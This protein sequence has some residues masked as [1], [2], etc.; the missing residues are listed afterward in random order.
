MRG[1]WKSMFDDGT[2]GGLFGS[3]RAAEESQMQ[4][5]NNPEPS[6][7]ISAKQYDHH[8]TSGHRFENYL[9]DEPFE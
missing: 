9:V 6:K 5:L 3:E 1:F 4:S 8:Y 7:L 2:P